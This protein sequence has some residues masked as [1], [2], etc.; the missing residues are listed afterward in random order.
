MES[1]ILM[2]IIPFQVLV[3]S[4]FLH[5]YQALLNDIILHT[6]D[7]RI[8]VAYKPASFR[9][10]WKFRMTLMIH[11]LLPKISGLPNIKQFH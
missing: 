4:W 10:I 3:Q 7:K 8:R 6:I 1:D 2:V 11:N 5:K 9:Q